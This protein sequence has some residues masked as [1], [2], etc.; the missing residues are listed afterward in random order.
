M[1]SLFNGRDLG[2]MIFV[3]GIRD[4]QEGLIAPDRDLR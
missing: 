3:S 2:Y 4:S 1:I